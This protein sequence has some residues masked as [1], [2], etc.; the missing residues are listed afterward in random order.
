MLSPEVKEI[1]MTSSLDSG[2]ASLEIERLE[3]GPDLLARLMENE[4]SLQET[5]APVGVITP[6]FR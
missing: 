1:I 2:P 5:D 6:L 3:V 4:D